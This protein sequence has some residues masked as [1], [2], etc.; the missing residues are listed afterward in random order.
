MIWLPGAKVHFSGFESGSGNGSR[1]TILIEK[2]AKSAVWS[3]NADFEPPG[4]NSLGFHGILRN[5]ME[6]HR[7]LWD[8]MDLLGP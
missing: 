2:M 3:Q 8:S 4:W 5:F 1:G 7:I 6:F